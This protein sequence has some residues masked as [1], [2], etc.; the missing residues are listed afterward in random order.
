MSIQPMRGFRADVP[1]KGLSGN[2][3]VASGKQNVGSVGD[4]TSTRADWV[5]LPLLQRD[6]DGA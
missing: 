1:G 4:L 3:R 6:R 5:R 2:E